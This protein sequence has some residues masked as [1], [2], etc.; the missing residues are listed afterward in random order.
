ARARHDPGLG[1]ELDRPRVDGEAA[2]LGAPD[3]VDPDLAGVAVD[4]DL[5]D[6]RRVGS[7]AERHADA[8]TGDHTGAAARVAGR[9]RTRLPGRHLRDHV[10]HVDEALVGQGREAELDRIL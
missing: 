1:T 2:I 10:D 6:V 8:A 3:L 4:L 9:R 7:V 5:R